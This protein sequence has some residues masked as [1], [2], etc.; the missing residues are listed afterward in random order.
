MP[1]HKTTASLSSLERS[2]LLATFTSSTA[3]IVAQENNKPL[4]GS[5]LVFGRKRQAKAGKL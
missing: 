1:K 3:L 4:S 2:M 5:I